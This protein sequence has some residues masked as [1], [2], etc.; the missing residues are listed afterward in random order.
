M[1]IAYFDYWTKGI[2]N[3]EILDAEL[4]A[5]GH[6]TLLLHFGSWRGPCAPEEQVRGILCRDITYYKTHFIYEMLRRERPDV[7]ISLNT[8]YL[9]DR[10]MVLACRTLGIKTVFMMHGNRIWD[11]A[12]SDGQYMN[13]L[14]KSLN[15]KFRKVLKAPKYLYQV[16]PNYLYSLKR[17]AGLS[18]RTLPVIFQYIKNPA[19]AS[20]FP[21]DAAELFHD[22]CLVYSNCEAKYYLQI[23][24]PNAKIKVTGSPKHDPLLKRLRDKTF[25]SSRLPVALREKLERGERYVLILDEALPETLGFAG[26]TNEYRHDYIQSLSERFLKE[27]LFV[28]IKA[29]PTSN[30]K[31]LQQAT[32]E[33]VL[34]YQTEDLNDLI[35][36]SELCVVHS[37]TTVAN[38]VLI[39]KPILQPRWGRSEALPTA[40]IKLGVSQAWLK[41]SDPIAFAIDEAKRQ[42]FKLHYITVL[43]PVAVQNIIHEIET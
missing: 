16:I 27:K 18:W 39:G 10:A 17:G 15:S 37:S 25:K 7:V 28:V 24:Y 34:L 1:K 23:G 8:T 12:E 6:Q 30:L 33:N 2:A 43:E 19:R 26:W 3:F 5:R 22:K 4:R 31:V 41:L 20:Y 9:P 21:T 38:C 36:F 42:A 29:H 11:D 40:Y 14:E 35:Y 32:N 13:S